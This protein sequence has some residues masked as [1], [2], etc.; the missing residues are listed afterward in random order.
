MWNHPV[1]HDTWQI[2]HS[3]LYPSQL[4]LVLD[5]ATTE[6]ASLSW[7]TGSWLGYIPRW[8][9]RP[10]VVTHP[11]T[12]RTQPRITSFLRR[13]ML[14]L[15]QA[16]NSYDITHASKSADVIV[17]DPLMLEN[18]TGNVSCP[19]GMHTISVPPGSSIFDS[20]MT[21]NLWLFDLMFACMPS[22]CRAQYIYQVWFW[23]LE[24]FSIQSTDKQIDTV[25]RET[26]THKLQTLL[27]TLTMGWLLLAWLMYVPDSGT[28]ARVSLSS[29]FLAVNDDIPS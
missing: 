14:P 29:L 4:K 23:Q 24:P 13:M 7:P 28:G 25:Y 3:R 12:N 18:Q 5:L 27:V 22:N 2:L 15:C 8:Y 9:T 10:K 26:Y 11:S 19:I 20:C 16:T 6:D 17:I 21:L 1:L